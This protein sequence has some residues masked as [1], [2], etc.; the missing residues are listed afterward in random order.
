V[1][2]SSDVGRRDDKRYPERRLVA[3]LVGLEVSP[4]DPPLAEAFGSA[5]A[6]TNA[7][8][9]WRRSGAGRLGHGGKSTDR[10]LRALLATF[11][12][13]SGDLSPGNSVGLTDVLEDDLA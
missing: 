4:L 13:A 7:V 8:G 11:A 6:G 12:L 3:L 10:Q 1:R 2:R 5:S 9:S